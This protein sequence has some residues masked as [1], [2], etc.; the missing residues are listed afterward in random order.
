MTY[1]RSKTSG[2]KVVCPHVCKTYMK[3]SS[4]VPET[5]MQGKHSGKEN[6]SLK[7]VLAFTSAIKTLL[8]LSRGEMFLHVLQS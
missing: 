8:G 7:Q 3:I 2:G 1:S 4:S 5:V 6:I